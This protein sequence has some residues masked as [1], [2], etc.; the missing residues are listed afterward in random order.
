MDR[1]VYGRATLRLRRKA[2]DGVK[3]CVGRRSVNGW[4]RALF[5]SQSAWVLVVGGEN[6]GSK[7][8]TEREKRG[9]ATES[10]IVI[11]R[12]AC[13]EPAHI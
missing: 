7:T 12:I 3:G 4:T 2:D 8:M 11:S 9:L 5:Q 1:A 10:L 6:D 13:R